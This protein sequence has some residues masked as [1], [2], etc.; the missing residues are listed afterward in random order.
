MPRAEVYESSLS[1]VFNSM[2]FPVEPAWIRLKNHL[3]KSSDQ[4]HLES[5]YSFLD[6]AL[7]N[8]SL[9]GLI[10][11]GAPVEEMPFFQVRYWE[12]LLQ[13][14][15]YARQNISS[16]LGLCW[17]G[18]ALA[19]YLGIEKTI[20]RQKLFGVFENNSL[21]RKHP[22]GLDRNDSFFFP[23]SRH[24]GI[25]DS[26]MEQA[27]KAGKVE[28]LAHGRET[29]YSIFCSPDCRF[30]MHLGHPEYRAERLL[31]EYRRDLAL[32]RKDVPPPLNIEATAPETT[33]RA[34]GLAFFQQWLAYINNGASANS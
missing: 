27:N 3:Y 33:W 10:L 7:E 11:S 17:G 8:G 19:A 32:G 9:D 31:E 14:F 30:L 16:T 23:H 4:V 1:D 15:D 22:F 2:P 24:A 13:V 20:Y 6:K 34:D 28:L 5:T 21:V 29:G 18:L 12:E 26:I 25:D